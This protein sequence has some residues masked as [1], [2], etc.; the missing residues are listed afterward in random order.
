MS[1][2]DLSWFRQGRK[3]YHQVA[4]KYQRVSIVEPVDVVVDVSQLA[5]VAL[6]VITDAKTLG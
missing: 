1:E 2:K 6:G 3:L 5:V 4:M